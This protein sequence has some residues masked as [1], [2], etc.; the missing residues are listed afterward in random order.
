MLVLTRRIGEAVQVGSAVV[1]ILEST[2]SRVRLG[3]VAPLEVDI[4]RV[5]LLPPPDATTPS[6]NRTP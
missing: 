5:E 6:P 2:P 1:T 3:F 4:T